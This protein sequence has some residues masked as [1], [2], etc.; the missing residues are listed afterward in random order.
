MKIKLEIPEWADERH[1]YVMAGIEVAA[2]KSAHEKDFKV[3]V[4]RCSN[5]GD[6]C[7]NLGVGWGMGRKENGEC[8]HLEADGP[9]TRCGL[10]GDRPFFCGVGLQQKG[11]YPHCTVEYK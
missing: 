3:K 8:I 1:I 5:C 11:R 7:R 9:Q 4:S 2:R 10:L 6:C